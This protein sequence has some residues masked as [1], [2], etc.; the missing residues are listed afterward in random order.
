[1]L[2]EAIWSQ[3]ELGISVAL[4]MLPYLMVGMVVVSLWVVTEALRG[5]MEPYWTLMELDERLNS[6]E[7]EFF[8][9][10]FDEESD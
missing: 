3:V 7:Q 6:V 1:M 9:F 8:G 10:L 4:G 2:S 5:N